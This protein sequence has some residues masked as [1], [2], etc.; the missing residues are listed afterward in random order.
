MWQNLIFLNDSSNTGNWVQRDENQLLW[1]LT[2]KTDTLLTLHRKAQEADKCT[3]QKMGKY[4]VECNFLE[5]KWLLHSR[6]NCIRPSQLNFCHRWGGDLYVPPILGS[7]CQWWKLGEEEW[8]FCEGEVTVKCF[9]LQKI[10][11]YICTYGQ[12]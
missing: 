2:Y 10:T 8:F 12:C 1:M 5:I 4:T 3:I 7:Y 6:K 9:K 11:P